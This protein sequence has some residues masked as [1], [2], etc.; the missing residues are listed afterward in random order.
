MRIQ[1]IS[2]MEQVMYEPP[3]YWKIDEI[4]TVPEEHGKLILTN[5]NFRLYHVE[6]EKKEKPKK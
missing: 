1:N 2:G 4:K 5:Q 3:Y 6:K